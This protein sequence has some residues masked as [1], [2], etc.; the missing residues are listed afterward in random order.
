V[1]RSGGAACLID[2]EHAFDPGY[3]QVGALPACCGMLRPAACGLQHL[4][5]AAACCCC[6]RCC[7]PPAADHP[8]RLGCLPASRRVAARRASSAALTAPTGC[9]PAPQALGLDLASLLHSQPESGEEALQVGRQGP[10]P[11][12]ELMSQEM[13]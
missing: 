9:P 12:D 13:G 4:L 7:R 3:A 10:G 8:W 6:C 11:W 5:P 1:Q 2:V